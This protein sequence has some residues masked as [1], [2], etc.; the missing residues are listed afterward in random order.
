MHSPCHLPVTE[1]LPLLASGALTSVG[2]TEAYFAAI[3]A[4][5]GGIHAYLETFEADALA[6][7]AA[8][9]ARR[10]AGR[11][12]SPLDGIPVAV[13]DNIVM[14]GRI[15]SCASRMLADFRSPYDA[16]VITRLRRAGMP[17]L[18]RL[19]MD[20][21]AMGGSTET[22]FFDPTRNP[23]DPTR[24]PGGSSGGSAA[25]VAAGMA[26]L[27]LGSDT[28]GS[29][30]QPAS[31][32]GVV[33]VK[34][35]YGAVSRYGLVAFASSLDQ[36][37]V[38]A[39]TAA[40]AALL[41]DVI[42]GPDERDM[43]SDTSLVHAYSGASC[44]LSALVIGL[45]QEHADAEVTAAVQAAAA[46]FEQQGARLCPVSIPSLSCALS[47]YYVLSSAEAS[48]NLA[49]YD[50]V[51]YGHR[52]A[53]YADLDE[54][55]RKS[56]Q[57]GFGDEVKRRIL[58]GTFALSSGYQDEYYLKAMA[59][60]ELLRRETDAAL[61]SCDLLLSPTAPTAAYRFGER[62]NPLEMYQ[63]DLF[64]VPANLTGLPAL[65]VP[66]GVTQDGLPIGLHLTGR[67]GGLG[68]LLAAAS[69]WEG[70]AAQ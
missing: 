20:E 33:G 12:L 54:L 67:R 68:T 50:G 55:Y 69:A 25:A 64:T 61:T 52:A 24:V 2:L 35:A 70:R 34:P 17:L 23:V 5:D 36:I 39:R 62:Q 66:C 43:T 3:R 30:R 19:N 59:A 38:L 49:R 41:L 53:S 31:F 15:C 48:S 57:E 18:G 60:R 27:A 21:F 32:C 28:G 16:A 1:L 47:A 29:I 65:S 63:G 9:D 42:C 51:R 6:E 45:P 56:R 46:W 44:D 14:R 37:G 22:S 8:S 26:P 4:Q 10:A 11:L 7:A 13:K 40:D 58:L